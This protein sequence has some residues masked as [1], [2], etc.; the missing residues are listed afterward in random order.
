MEEC[1]FNLS[2]APAGML[3]ARTC[4]PRVTFPGGIYAGV[5]PRRSLAAADIWHNDGYKSRLRLETD[6]DKERLR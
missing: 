1:T 3:A 2:L 5:G 6:R 4:G